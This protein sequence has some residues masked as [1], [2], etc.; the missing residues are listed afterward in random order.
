MI[1]NED[2]WEDLPPTDAQLDY[3]AGLC[4]QLG[5]HEPDPE[6]MADASRTIDS[7]KFRLEEE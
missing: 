6:S 7:L 1:R 3:I 4:E 5:A 2:H